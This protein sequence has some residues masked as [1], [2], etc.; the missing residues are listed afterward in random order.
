MLN[1]PSILIVAAAWFNPCGESSTVDE[2]IK[3]IDEEINLPDRAFAR[4]SYARYY[5]IEEVE[6]QRSGGDSVRV[7]WLR[8]Y[9]KEFSPGVY[10]VKQGEDFPRYLK[11]DGGCRTIRGAVDAATR[12]VLFLECGPER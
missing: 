3:S 12:K 5:K 1:Y 11:T 8:Y 6:P 7:V 4:A 2:L 9:A 10:F